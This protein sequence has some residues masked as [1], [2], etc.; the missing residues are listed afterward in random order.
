MRLY[1]DKS[2]QPPT[3]GEKIAAGKGEEK[4]EEGKKEEVEEEE[5]AVE[6]EAED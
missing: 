6:K 3:L 1:F 5:R 2:L 4:E